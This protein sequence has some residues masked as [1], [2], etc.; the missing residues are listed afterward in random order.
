MSA[1]SDRIDP[2]DLQRRR[3]L[4]GIAASAGA[5]AFA[6]AALALAE[7]AADTTLEEA[8]SRFNNIRIG[9]R[10]SLRTMYF[11]SDEGVQYI[12]SRVDISRPQRLD[13]DY[14]RTMMAGFLLQPA[15]KRVLM[16]GLGG[17][18]ISNYLRA[19]FPEIEIDA[20]DIDP[21]VVRLAQRYFNVPRDDP[22]YRTHVADGRLFI[23]EAPANARWDMI[24]LDAFRGVFVPYHL[25]TAEFYRACLNRL[26]PQGVVVANLHNATRMYPHDRNTLAAVF[27]QRYS[28][29]SESRNQTT[30]VAS[31]DPTRIGPYQMRRNARTLSRHFDFDL[32]GLAARYYLR[33]DWELD[34]EVLHDDF[35]PADLQQAAKR[36]NKTCISDCRYTN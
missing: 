11:V 19:Q 1:R 35:K 24:I 2:W 16:L 30:F 3:F 22:S 26:S 27:P 6:P 33:T 15:P 32:L 28:F 12:E 36:H 8:R 23:E 10:G 20:I 18:Q 21:E 17:G 5:M 13:L 29:V 9:Q 4:R 31:A 25:K 7:E 14:S 34:A